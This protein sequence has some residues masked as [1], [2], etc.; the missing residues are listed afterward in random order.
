M[1]ARVSVFAHLSQVLPP[2]SVT[3]PEP[4]SVP[5][6]GYSAVMEVIA[7]GAGTVLGGFHAEVTSRRP[8]LSRGTVIAQAREPDLVDDDVAEA[9]RGSVQSFVPLE[10]PQFEIFLDPASPVIR[11]ALGDDGRPV[12]PTPAIPARLRPGEH[13]KFIF[14]PVT[15][16]KRLVH[17][18]LTLDWHVPG[19]SPQAARWNLVVTGETGFWAFHPDGRERT[20]ASVRE[21]GADHWMPLFDPPGNSNLQQGSPNHY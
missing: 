5:S 13:G 6:T 11:P 15:G 12:R 4:V 10:V 14:T 3:G 7:G 16:D 18:V 17:W 9:A 20:P 19:Q 2:S 1:A 8:L 21:A